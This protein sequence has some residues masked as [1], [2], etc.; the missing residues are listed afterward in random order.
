MATDNSG[1]ALS[2]S[3]RIFNDSEEMVDLLVSLGADIN[4][5]KTLMCLHVHGPSKS[6]ELQSKCDLRQPDVSI[7][8]N[9]LKKME[10]IRIISSASKGRGRPSHIYELA[11]PLNEALVPFRRQAKERLSILQNQLSR[12]TELANSASD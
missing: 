9:K 10:V 4:T 3:N 8:I 5:A 12:L 6:S 7:S 11:M 1:S 2:D